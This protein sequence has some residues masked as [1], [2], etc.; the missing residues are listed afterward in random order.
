MIRGN[1]A[2]FLSFSVHTLIALFAVAL[3]Q[4][5]PAKQGGEV[6]YKIALSC[7]MEHAE[8]APAACFCDACGEM[9]EEVP[10]PKPVEAKKP[11]A[12]TKTV[13]K[14]VAAEK[15]E[16]LEPVKKAVVPAAA[17]IEAPQESAAVLEPVAA[18]PETAEEGSAEEAAEASAA[19]APSAESSVA[20]ESTEMLPE[21]VSAEALYLQEHIRQIA[22]LLREN[23]YYPRIARKRGITGDVTVSFELLKNGEVRNVE[24]VTG[25]RSILNRAAIKTIERLSGEFPRP[26][27][28]LML[29]V[30]IN[31]RLQ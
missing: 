20:T 2:L 26:D 7:L 29:Q 5:W 1:K 19:S 12:E 23:L 11:A 14:P 24:V 25:D 8:A 15:P 3:Y 30:P 27:E 22:L 18:V 16:I 13:P 9:A 21:A 17:A 10:Q 4:Q 31:Y 6:R 28:P